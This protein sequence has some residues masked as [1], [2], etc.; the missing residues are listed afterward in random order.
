MI[1]S[2]TSENRKTIQ[3]GGWAT[4][5]ALCLCLLSNMP[6]SSQTVVPVTKMWVVTSLQRVFPTSPTVDQKDIQILSA[7]NAT[8]SF[9]VVLRNET[10]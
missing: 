4:T 1:S 9:Q 8:V 2:F 7:R 6:A 3:S 10:A 5:L